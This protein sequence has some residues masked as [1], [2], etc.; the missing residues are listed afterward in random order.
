MFKALVERIVTLSL[1]LEIR[2]SLEFSCLVSLAYFWFGESR[3]KIFIAVSLLRMLFHPIFV[4]T[5]VITYAVG[6]AW[7]AQDELEVIA[8]HP[9]RDHSFFVDEFDNLYKFVPRIVKNICTEFNSQPRNWV[10]GR[11]LAVLVNLGTICQHCPSCWGIRRG[12]SLGR[13]GRNTCIV[14]ILCYWWFK[15]FKTCLLKSWPSSSRLGSNAALFG[16]CWRVRN[17]TAVWIELFWD[18]CFYF[19]LELC[20]LPYVSF[21]FLSWGGRSGLNKCLKNYMDIFWSCD[22]KSLGGGAS[23]AIPFLAI[24]EK[25]VLEPGIH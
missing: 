8:T 11:Q 22:E 21:F 5:G 6:I 7:A 12:Q 4:S 14:T 17:L 25:S 16:V 15:C 20:N 19:S 2:A 18:V 10:R 13:A 23:S 1:F 3:G 24:K 9:A